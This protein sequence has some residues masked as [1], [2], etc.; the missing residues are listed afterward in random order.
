[1]ASVKLTSGVSLVRGKER[2]RPIGEGSVAYTQARHARSDHG[3]GLGLQAPGFVRPTAA[4]VWSQ[5]ISPD[6][7]LARESRRELRLAMKAKKQRPI[8]T[9]YNGRC[10]VN[11]VE[12]KGPLRGSFPTSHTAAIVGRAH[13]ADAKTVHVIHDESGVVVERKSYER[14]ADFS[15]LFD[16]PV[17]DIEGVGNS[18]DDEPSA[19]QFAHLSG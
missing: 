1:M 19:D 15:Q 10:W 9:I 16:S 8:L 14:L 17:R 3:L 2:Y 12:G 5:A 4:V 13:A 11:V 6:F 7:G 18:G